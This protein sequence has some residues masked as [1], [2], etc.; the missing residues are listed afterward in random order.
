MKCCTIGQYFLK[1]SSSDWWSYRL[2]PNSGIHESLRNGIWGK[3]CCFNAIGCFSAVGLLLL[4]LKINMIFIFNILWKFW[5]S[6]S[7]SH[8]VARNLLIVWEAVTLRHEE[9][10][11]FVFSLSGMQTYLQSLF[12]YSMCIYTV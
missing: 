9:F 2:C 6:C 5:I 3:C 12:R 11:C 7:I 4:W 10:Y 8:P 1:K